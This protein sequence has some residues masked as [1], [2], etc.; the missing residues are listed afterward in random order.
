[1][2]RLAVVLAGIAL[3][4]PASALAHPLGN[5]TINRYAGV[6]LSGSRVY[7]H[8]AVDLAEIPTY[9]EGARFRRPGIARTASTMSAR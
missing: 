1:M 4:A 2:R 3:L 5:F 7:L 6:E 9:Q 8:Y